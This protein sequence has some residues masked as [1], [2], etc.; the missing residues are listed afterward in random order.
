MADFDDI[1]FTFLYIDLY[2][3]GKDWYYPE[4][5]IPYNMLRYIVR[6]EAEFFI[7]G[8][9]IHVKQNDIVY[10]P[11]GCNLSCCMLSDSFEFYSIRFITSFFWEGR[12]V[13]KE[14]YG[15]QSVIEARGEEIYFEEIY[16]WIKSKHVAKKSFIRGYLYILIASL[17]T[18]G[19][20][21]CTQANVKDT[22]EYDLEKIVFRELKCNKIDSR[23]RIVADYITLHPEEKFTP[24]KMAQ[25]IG[26]SKQ[27]FSSLFKENMGKSPMEYAKEIKLSTAARKLLVS[28][29]SVNE[30]AYSVGYGDPNYFIREFKNAFGCTPNRYRTEAKEL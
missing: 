28:T 19:V 3:M 9:K 12:D 1:K 4:S 24:E 13:L 18:R 20:S 21:G 2:S 23:I 25:M 22:G 16:K 7:D 30:I 26:L 27:R 5:R 15:L 6:G 14:Y 29:D 8:E 11:H 10:I 17:S